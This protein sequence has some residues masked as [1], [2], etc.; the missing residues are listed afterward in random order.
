[1]SWQ[2]LKFSKYEGL[3][4]PQVLFLDPGWFFHMI[5]Q[6]DYK[7]YKTRGEFN[8]LLKR[9]CSVF[10]PESFDPDSHV[11]YYFDPDDNKFLN[12][13]IV[14]ASKPIGA[15]LL[16]CIRKEVVD[17]SVVYENDP[18]DKLGYTFFLKTF[19]LYYFGDKDYY[20]N[21]EVCEKFFDDKWNFPTKD[22][23]KRRPTGLFPFTES[24]LRQK[25]R[26]IR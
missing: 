12:F 19:R 17:F 5:H 23:P 1:M 16:K 21:K 2:K 26:I 24:E 13:S 6:T 7:K 20:T 8:R 22:R 11:E 18:E 25:C 14:P 15:R 9:A 10:T 4:L 3:T